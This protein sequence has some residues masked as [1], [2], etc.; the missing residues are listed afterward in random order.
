M[1]LAIGF[2]YVLVT[3]IAC[4]TVYYGA[5]FIEYSWNVIVSK[6]PP[7]VPAID[8]EC[9]AVANQI[10]VFYPRAKTVLELGSGYGGLARY[11]ARN[12]NACVIGVERMPAT[13][14]ISWGLDKL[15]RVKSRTVWGDVF[16]Y[17]ENMDG[18][19]DIVV[20]YM[21]PEVTAGLVR[22]ANKFNVLISVD[23]EIP[24]IKTVRVVDVCDGCTR[25]RGKKYP[26]RLYVYEFNRG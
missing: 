4:V 17:L 2:I 21:G 5:K 25:Y 19:A 22:Y 11:I 16:Q 14:L 13:A 10:N 26:H 23:F 3:V 12:T 18:Q 15:C 8:A 7:F 24:E 20:A 6:Q 1:N 9:A